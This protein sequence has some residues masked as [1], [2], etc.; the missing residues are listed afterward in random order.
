M[1]SD[2]A[3]VFVDEFLNTANDLCKRKI[4]LSGY[5]FEN[6]VEAHRFVYPIKL[7]SS[8]IPFD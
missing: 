3:I 1:S 7:R 4:G 6:V 5:L 2:E 8:V